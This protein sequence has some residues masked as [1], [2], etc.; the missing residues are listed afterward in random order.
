VTTGSFRFVL[1]R[2][3]AA[4]PSVPEPLY[5]L[6]MENTGATRGAAE[7]PHPVFRQAG[8]GNPKRGHFF[9]R[10]WFPHLQLFPDA[11]HLPIFPEFASRYAFAPSPEANRL[12]TMPS[13]PGAAVIGGRLPGNHQT[14]TRWPF[15]DGYGMARYN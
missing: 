13:F 4:F 5:I 14:G 1:I 6:H 11:N 15:V 2:P 12:A 8:G 3:A 9:R 10:F 7:F